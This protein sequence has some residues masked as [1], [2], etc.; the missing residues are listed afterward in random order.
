MGARGRAGDESERRPLRADA[1]LAE[2]DQAVAADAT[3]DRG[4]GFL[5]GVFAGVFAGVRGLAG[6]FARMTT[7]FFADLA[8]VG[9][10][11]AEAGEGVVLAGVGAGAGCS[12]AGFAGVGAGGG[13]AAAA[14]AA[15][16]SSASARAGAAAP[17]PRRR[18]LGMRCW[19]LGGG[20]LASA[21]AGGG[22]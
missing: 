9:V 17:P 6:D 20:A 2:A 10:G 8:G 21:V 1:F 14:G 5:V 22:A 16:D 13:S 15:G 12:A 18:L 4:D 19:A 11:F 7:L 3:R